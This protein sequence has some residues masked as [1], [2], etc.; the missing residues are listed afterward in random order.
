MV[1]DLICAYKPAHDIILEHFWPLDHC[2]YKGKLGT[3]GQAFTAL[4]S[5]P[6]L[7]TLTLM[8][9]LSRVDR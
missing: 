1:D 9:K 4:N 7:P 8:D 3:L 6:F 5:F 2:N